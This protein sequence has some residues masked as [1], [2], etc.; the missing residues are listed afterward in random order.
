MWNL[1]SVK[2][3]PA[4]LNVC[5][6][7]QYL[8]DPEK[9]ANLLQIPQFF[10]LD[11]YTSSRQ[12]KVTVPC[13]FICVHF[14]WFSIVIHLETQQY[15]LHFG[16]LLKSLIRVLLTVEL[17]SK[18]LVRVLVETQVKSCWHENVQMFSVAGFDWFCQYLRSRNTCLLQFRACQGAA[19]V[20]YSLQM[21]SRKRLAYEVTYT[22]ATYTSLVCDV[23]ESGCQTQ[24]GSIQGCVSVAFRWQ[25]G[26]GNNQDHKSTEKHY[27]PFGRAWGFTF[28][29]SL[30]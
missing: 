4:W 16:A 17:Q 5:Q 3:C 28:G 11:I 10:D 27:F 20:V 21:K 18:L 22:Y 13:F 14:V 7:P 1:D 30:I 26:G 19:I 29:F 9:V 2:L 23:T 8:M 15:G 6:F 12:E 25:F 24:N